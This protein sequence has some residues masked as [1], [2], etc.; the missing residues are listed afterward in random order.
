MNR[1][2]SSWLRGA[3][4]VLALGIATGAREATERPETSQEAAAAAYAL[5][6][7]W[8]MERQRLNQALEDYEVAERRREVF[9]D[10]ISSLYSRLGAAVRQES[11]AEG[12]APEERGSLEVELAQ[13]EQ[14]EEA[15]RQDLQRLRER[16][17]DARERMGYLNAR[18]GELKRVA[19]EEPEGISGAWEITYLPSND[20]AVFSLRQSG[21]IIS[22][23]YQQ[24]GGFRGSLQ[25][26]LINNK[27]V[28]HRIDSKLGPISDLEGVV[29]TD[30]KS[31]KGTWTSRVIGDG[32]PPNGAWTARK[33]ESRKKADEG[34][35]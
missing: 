21:V 9:R 19:P 35:P 26:T 8:E 1:Q 31:V 27:L 16:I 17:A 7:G 30:Q 15:V 23:E 11:P 12:D 28:L 22:G 4:A 13:L 34:A 25:G 10:R 3:V 32:T 18:M 29:S 33:R 6:V 2:E 14:G 24:D 5:K 20:K